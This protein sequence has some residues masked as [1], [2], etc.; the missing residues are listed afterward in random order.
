MWFDKCAMPR[1]YINERILIFFNI[2]DLLEL[3]I[4]P[5]SKTTA[6]HSVTNGQANINSL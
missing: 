4:I 6:A 2:I 1:A 3:F 5:L